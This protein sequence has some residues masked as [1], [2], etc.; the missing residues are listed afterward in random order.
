MNKELTLEEKFNKVIELLTNRLIFH[1]ISEDEKLDKLYPPNNERGDIRIAYIDK[2]SDKCYSSIE[3]IERILKAVA[4]ECVLRAEQAREDFRKE[5]YK[6]Y[7]GM[8]GIL[9]TLHY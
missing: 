3:E 2:N 8:H 5:G 6:E 1:Y 7:E 4:P 9:G